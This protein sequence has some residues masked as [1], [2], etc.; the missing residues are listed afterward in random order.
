MAAGVVVFSAA[1]F[2]TTASF[3]S[4]DYTQSQAQA[5]KQVYS[6]HCA[7]CHGTNLLGK[8]G[9][10]LG[11]SQFASSLQ[12][13][14]MSAQQLFD[15]MKTHMPANAPGSLSD[16]QYLDTL[17]YILSQNGYPAGSTALSSSTIANVKLLPYPS[18][19]GSGQTTG[20]K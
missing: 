2:D 16:Q 10:P 5:G 13:S 12:F 20:S 1:A 18:Q 17:A 9:P 19:G 6:T 14:K 15:Y 3:A 8:A 7:L 4:G 11:G